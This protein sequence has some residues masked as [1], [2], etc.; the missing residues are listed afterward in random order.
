MQNRAIMFRRDFR[1]QDYFRLTAKTGVAYR[2]IFCSVFIMGECHGMVCSVR[3]DF[4]RCCGGVN[5]R[6]PVLG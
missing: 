3:P 2:R 1:F 5:R 6:R 4:W